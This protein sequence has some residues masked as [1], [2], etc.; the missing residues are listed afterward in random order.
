MDTFGIL[1]K[2]CCM[3]VH[4]MDILEHIC[5]YH[6]GQILLYK[7]N[8]VSFLGHSY[9]LILLGGVKQFSKS[10]KKFSH[11]L[12]PKV[13]NKSYFR[14]IHTKA[15]ITAISF[16]ARTVKINWIFVSTALCWTFCATFS[17]VPE[18]SW[19]TGTCPCG[20]DWHNRCAV[21]WITM[22]LF[23][24][25]IFNELVNFKRITTWRFTVFDA[26]AAF[27]SFETRFT[28]TC[29]IF[30]FIWIENGWTE[31]SVA[32]AILITCT[33]ALYH[34]WNLIVNANETFHFWNAVAVCISSIS[35]VTNAFIF[36]YLSTVAL[37]L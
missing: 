3:V 24:A 14:L 37:L 26:I 8:Q 29:K 25:I 6:H 5:Y 30:F 11:V 16:V 10:R 9:I 20:V 35:T 21:A 31:T 2:G 27:I 23:V 19:F 33:G 4:S 36:T 32:I 17:F 12:M 13:E 1:H 15:F 28:D 18:C 7:C 34:F 22:C